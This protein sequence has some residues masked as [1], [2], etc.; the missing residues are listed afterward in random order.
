VLVAEFMEQ[1]RASQVRLAAI[2][3]HRSG[4]AA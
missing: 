2:L 1:D 4:S 3:P